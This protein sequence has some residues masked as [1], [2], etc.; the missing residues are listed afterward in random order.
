M[1]TFGIGIQTSA[2]LGGG[3][4]TSTSITIDDN[5]NV[6]LTTTNVGGGYGG[7]GV[8]SSFQ[9]GYTNADTVY[10]LQGPVLQ[11]GASGGEYIVG[12]AEYTTSHD[13]TVKGGNISL[14]VGAGTPLEEHAETGNTTVLPIY[15]NSNNKKCN[16]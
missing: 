10:D 6:A 5:G 9:V 15:E 8:G 4:S 2:G 14:G 13:G 3:G 12:G 16:K 11:T 7:A 1:W